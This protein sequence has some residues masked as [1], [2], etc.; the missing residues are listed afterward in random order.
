MKHKIFLKLHYIKYFTDSNVVYNVVKWILDN[1]FYSHDKIIGLEYSNSRLEHSLKVLDA[2]H[3]RN[4]DE[5]I[6]YNCMTL[7]ELIRTGKYGEIKCHIFEDS[8]YIMYY[9][10]EELSEDN[11]P[12]LLE[13]TEGV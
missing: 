7:T 6:Q 8:G 1:F 10:K 2:A 11:S 12:F 13:D 4:L 9:I 3:K 5:L